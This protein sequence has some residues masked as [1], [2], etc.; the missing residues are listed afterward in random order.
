MPSRI[1]LYL[2]AGMLASTI[3]FAQL[4]TASIV[5]TIIDPSGAVIPKATVEVQNQG[6]AA[7][8]SLI[9]DSNGNFV[10]PVLQIGAYR[11]T[12]SAPGFKTHITENITL[13]V[14][15]RARVDVT[16][17]P[18]V[19]SE[20]VTVV[21][22]A[23]VVD[24]AS[25]TLGGVVNTQQVSEL[26]LNGRSLTQ[27][28]VVVPGVVFLGPQRSMNGA[29]QGRLFESGLKYLVDGGDSGQVDSDLGDGGYQSG[30]RISRASVDSIAEVRVVES[31]YSAEYGGSVGG[32][33]NFITKSGANQLHGSLFEYFRN[34]VLDARN[35]FNVRPAVQPA[36]RL[37]QFGGSLSGPIIKDKFFYF[38]NYEAVRQRL[39]L[40]QNVFVPTD[41]FRATLSP[42]MQ[43]VVNQL[44]HANGP[45]SPT[46]PRLAQFIRGVSN[47]LTED[48]GSFKL[49]YAATDKDRLSIRHNRNQSTTLQNFGVQTGG[50]RSVP[51]ILQLTKLSYTKTITPTLL[52]EA[53]FAVNRWN[54]ADPGSDVDAVRSYPLTTIGGGSAG[55]GPTLFDLRVGNTSFTYL[56]TLSWVKGRHQLKIGGQVVRNRDNKASNLQGGVTY[57]SLDLFAANKPST[58]TTIGNPTVG[59][60]NTYYH[61]FVQDDIQVSRNLTANVG[62]RYQ[63]DSTPS[64][65]HGRIA[66]FDPLKG[67]LDPVGTNIFDAPALNFGP[68]VGLA[69][70]P[71]RSKKTVFRTGYG[72]FHSALIAAQA[73]SLPANVPGLNFNAAVSS[74]TD[75]TLVGFPFPD[76]TKFQGATS[77]WSMDKNWHTAATQNWSFNVQQGFG[78]NMVLEVGYIGNH[79]THL[80]PY[81]ELN[82][83][84]PALGHRIF[85][86][87]GPISQFWGCC[88]A[89]YNAL[90]TSFKRRYSHGLTFNVNYTW[91]HSIDQG[92][93]T[94][95]AQAQNFY[96]YGSEKGNSDYDARH[97]FQFDY[98]YEIPG[99][100]RIPKVVGSGWQING[101]TVLRSGLPVTVTCGCDSNGNG[102]FN[103]RADIVSSVSSTPGNYDLPTHQFNIAAFAAP[104]AGTVG[105]SGRN[106]LRGPSAYNTDFSLFKNFKVREGQSLQFRAEAFNL[107][108]T[109]EFSQPGASLAS[110]ATFGR[111]LSTIAT[112]GGFSSNRQMQ[113]A[114]RYG[115]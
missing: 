108:N 21:G 111:S 81:R 42:V 19:V 51:A 22:E 71:F 83:V 96:D 10:A 109:P 52:N 74:A 107:F 70:T 45:A 115:F 3:A 37:N 28:L 14:S 98:T 57:A 18:G 20:K 58:V 62:V 47:Q 68:R 79:S 5:G 8:V 91:S 64:E 75:P 50:F 9:T 78:D 82:P 24:T 15:D 69:Y 27:L 89:T 41:A 103:E 60:R 94:F 54:A 93:L 80:V 63:Y 88:G 87:F 90:Q 25:T 97:N 26:P 46:E 99:I 113:F 13:R 12:V 73:Q 31:S 1:V 110:P 105:N 35:Y 4:E 11:I 7:T 114:L 23:S 2:L 67:A 61:F 112:I 59:M 40:I 32:V 66:N 56:D 34:N 100:P 86:A 17:E 85:T 55:V 106:I 76:L 16:L 33:I 92:G 84:V 48:T 43:G 104:K 39:G 6:T 77:F 95:G 36:F 65:S 29:S 44:P 30:A 101:I 72:I 53:S 38:V 49:D 102:I